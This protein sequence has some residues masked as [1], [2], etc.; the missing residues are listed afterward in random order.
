M[1]SSAL[2]T[3][4]PQ[5]SVILDFTADDISASF[6]L[7]SGLRVLAGKRNRQPQGTQTLSDDMIGHWIGGAWRTD[8]AAAAL[9][10]PAT[11][12]LP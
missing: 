4:K 11:G 1:P 2:N 6:P 5:I 12:P 10:D 3:E 7:A 9:F 8:G